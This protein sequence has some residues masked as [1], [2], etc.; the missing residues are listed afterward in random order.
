[1]VKVGSLAATALVLLAAAHLSM[2]VAEAT[3]DSRGL[4]VLSLTAC[5]SDLAPSDDDDR[6]Q[7]G[8]VAIHP[9]PVLIGEALEW[10]A[11]AQLTSPAL[12]NVSTEDIFVR[13]SIDRKDFPEEIFGYFGLCDVL[14]EERGEAGC[15][16]L[17]V[18]LGTDGR[19]AFEV[20]RWVFVEWTLS[21]ARGGAPIVRVWGGVA[22]GAAAS[23]PFF[24]P[25]SLRSSS[26]AR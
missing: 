12:S 9:R 25:A 7:L 8:S 18:Y 16:R 2:A 20:G 4:Q 17:P 10:A 14:V 13:V 24:C 22:A 6:W 3:T 23:F 1:M 5:S 26:R 15:P 19:Y 11:K 21:C